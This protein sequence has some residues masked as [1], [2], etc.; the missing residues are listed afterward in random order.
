MA[1]DTSKPP[2]KGAAAAAG[3]KEAG[4]SSTSSSIKKPKLV[5]FSGCILCRARRKKCD[6]RKPGCSTCERLNIECLG[7]SSKR[8]L[9]LQ[10]KTN[11]ES[12]RA[13]ITA[14]LQRSGRVRRHGKGEAGGTLASR[15]SRVKGKEEDELEEEETDVKPEVLRFTFSLET[16]EDLGAAG[17]SSGSRERERKV[18]TGVKKE[19]G[20]GK[21]KKV[22]KG[23]FGSDR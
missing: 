13:E 1:K 14:F 17:G 11:L 10:N 23:E 22:V 9:Y 5:T 7:Y 3:K 2:T 18:A 8:P 4:S 12:V 15:R 6:E 20:K 19:K 21:G 16:K